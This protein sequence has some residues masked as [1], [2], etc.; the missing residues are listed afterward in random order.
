MKPFKSIVVSRHPVE[1]LWV[2]VRDQMPALAKMLDDIESVT[3]IERRTLQRGS[4]RLVNEWRARPQFPISLKSVIGSESFV[5][6]DHAEWTDAGKRCE[7]RIEP[8]FLPGKIHCH[9]STDYVPAMGG[10]GSRVTFE[11]ELSLDSHA[12]AGVGKLLE[13]SIMPIIESVVTVMI[14]KNFRRIV[15]AADRLLQKER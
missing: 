4:V 3:V 13:R 11:G 1:R 14:P 9:G 5:W 10:R 12:T 6:L 15:E 7:W 2:T 8:Q